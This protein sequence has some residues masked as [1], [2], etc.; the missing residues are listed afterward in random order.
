[1]FVFRLGNKTSP[2]GAPGDHTTDG[3]PGLEPPP[4]KLEIVNHRFR[5]G[6]L[7]KHEEN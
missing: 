7:Y 1:M 2:G 6:P 5:D 4:I 3:A